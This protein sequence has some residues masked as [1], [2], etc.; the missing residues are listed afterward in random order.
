M[1]LSGLSLC[2]KY[3]RK[4]KQNDLLIIEILDKIINKVVQF[5]KN[6]K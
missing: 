1:L 3:Y 2:V 4:R 5:T 6:K